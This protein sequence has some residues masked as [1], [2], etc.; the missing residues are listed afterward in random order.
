MTKKVM[1]C[2][3]S[4][5]SLAPGLG[6][7]VQL[8]MFPK[9]S[10]LEGAGEMLGVGLKESN[11]NGRSRNGEVTV[12]SDVLNLVASLPGILPFTD[13]FVLL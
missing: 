10:H 12:A 1:S 8:E 6:T 13:L 2:S 5:S 3:L 9:A 4:V 7:L 11:E